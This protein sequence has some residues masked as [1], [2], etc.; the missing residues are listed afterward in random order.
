MMYWGSHVVPLI[1]V[2]VIP[3]VWQG[4]T[5][6][7]NGSTVMSNFALKHLLQ[8]KTTNALRSLNQQNACTSIQIEWSIRDDSA[9]TENVSASH[10]TWD[11]THSTGSTLLP[12]VTGYLWHDNEIQR[13]ILPVDSSLQPKELPI[14]WLPSSDPT[15]LDPIPCVLQGYATTS[16]NSIQCSSSVTN[17]A[18]TATTLVR[19]L[20]SQCAMLPASIYHNGPPSSNESSCQMPATNFYHALLGESGQDFLT[21]EL[22]EEVLSNHNPDSIRELTVRMS[23]QCSR[24]IQIGTTKDAFLLHNA[25]LS[26]RQEFHQITRSYHHDTNVSTVSSIDLTTQTKSTIRTTPPRW[27]PTLLVHSP[28]HGDGKTKL[29]QAIAHT[30]G[31]SRIHIIRPGPLLAKYGIHADMALESLLHGI[32]VSAAVRSLD[33]PICIILDHIDAMMPP[34]L[35]GKSGGSGDA[36]VPIFNAIGKKRPSCFLLLF[37]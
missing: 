7:Q 1:Y 4:S 27:N 10:G 12:I 3:I 14:F 24:S 8:T 23:M 11:K 33:S 25:A 22:Q 18:I 37:S 6:H 17:V 31:C 19:V 32:L 28:H 2:E 5:E 21:K 16:G 26:R 9:K 15:V 13:A 36:A 30:I 35:S 34:L 20:P 29:V